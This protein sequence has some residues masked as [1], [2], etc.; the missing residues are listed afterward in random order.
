MSLD[1]QNYMGREQTLVKHIILQRY[2]LRLAVIV[3]SW[4]EAVTYVDCFS[5]PWENKS[6]DYS[7]TSFGIAVQELRKAQDELFKQSK[8]PRFRCFF[9]ERDKKA[10]AKLE[11]FCSKVSGLEAVPRNSDLEHSVVEIQN[12]YRQ[13]GK[14]NFAFTFIDPTGWT[15]F[16][17]DVIRPLLQHKPGEVLI[18]YMTSFIRRFIESK[19]PELI[20]G[21]DKL[22]GGS[23]FRAK[24][25]SVVEV[26]RDEAM[27]EEYARR[28]KQEGGFQFV[29]Y[30]PVFRPET[31][32]VHFHL[33]Y[34]TRHEKGLEV[35]KKEERKAV[36]TME[37]ARA[38]AQQ[39][40]RQ[41][42][43]DLELFPSKEMHDTRFYDSLRTK[44]LGKA[45]SK[46]RSL[47]S[48]KQAVDY[49]RLWEAA[50]TTPLVW[51]EDLN[52]FLFALKK[53]GTLKFIGLS[54][55]EKP[56]QGKGILVQLS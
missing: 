6:E 10:F 2:L 3:G 39:R 44:Y 51:K 31:N 47:L 53:G 13:G 34:C 43:G 18:N 9:L 29:C 48:S 22:Y 32:A 7:D 24:L 25:A 40:S 49:D 26:D 19:D 52:E 38:E 20:A 21:F 35:F 37:Q 5:G 33:I 50:L 55:R 12:F 14:N 46:V 17:M 28:I 4:A 16:E 45:Q 23:A 56:K 41:S 30:T 36:E 54:E 42:G 1:G 27:V 15:G 11:S 8:A